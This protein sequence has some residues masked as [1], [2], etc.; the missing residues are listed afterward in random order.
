[1]KFDMNA[2]PQSSG[3]DEYVSRNGKWLRPAAGTVLA[4][5]APV[6]MASVDPRAAAFL[7]VWLVPAA[8]VLGCF[9]IGLGA[10]V[11]DTVSGAV[12]RIVGFGAAA[13]FLLATLSR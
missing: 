11:T 2:E 4:I 1:M 12:V 7:P 6:L 5:A 9:V 10:S 13:G 8:G 3:I